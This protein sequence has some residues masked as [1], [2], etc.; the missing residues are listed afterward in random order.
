M[1]RSMSTALSGLRNHQVMIDV[2]GNDIA[3]V[4]TVGFKGSVAVFSDVLSQTLNGVQA[5]G[6][7]AAGTNPAQIGL[8][9]R[10]VGTQQS[11]T[12]GAIQR[13][14][15]NSDVAIQGDG[16]FVV[17]NGD[18]EYYT[19]AGSMNLDANGRL[20]TI[21]G[22]LVKGWQAGAN[23]VI[24]TNAAIGTLE[25]RVGDLLPPDQTTEVGI[26]GNL[27]A[28][29][30]IGTRSDMST[31]TY[32][33]QG[34]A[35]TLNLSFEKTAANEWTVTATANG[36]ALAPGSLTDNVLTF[37]AN[38]ELTVPADRNINIAASTIPGMPLPISLTLGTATGPARLTQ[39]AGDSTAGINQQNG[40]PAGSLQSFD[41][42]PDGVILGS[43]SNGRARAIG[44][45]AM[46][47]FANPGGLERVAGAWRATP[48]SGLVQIGTANTGGR[49][50]MLA[51]SLEMSN[52]DLAEE[53]TRLIVAQ[54]G[55]QGNARVITAS[56]EVLQE[57][58][59]LKR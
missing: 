52:V 16:F 38:G 23:G 13:T 44:Q 4:S 35:V 36:A 19:R 22:T 32:D 10:L 18:E 27:S 45:L 3:N 40:S 21:D 33:E 12:Q 54:R 31:L 7:A 20:A 49:G 47:V 9:S 29:A 14:E 50:T 53:F 26:G 37:G 15:R 58:V 55:F 2:V 39:F 57:V 5:P 48:N 1:I 25:I 42:A 34:R 56:D 46:A 43:Y 24:D 59:N 17:G 8:G 6:G 28:N 41:I 51:G 30:A 11:F